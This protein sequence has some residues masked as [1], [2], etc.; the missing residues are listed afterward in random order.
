MQDGTIIQ[1][2]QGLTEPAIKER[3]QL[4]NLG[5]GVLSAQNYMVVAIKERKQLIHLGQAIINLA[6][7]EA[8]EKADFPVRFFGTS[9]YQLIVY[10]SREG[11]GRFED[12]RIC[13]DTKA[14]RDAAYWE[15]IAKN[16]LDSRE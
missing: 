1:T 13:Y 11:L 15:A 7:I 9:E 10:Y 5:R 6:E 8:A 3:K 12:F 2:D 16:Q 14:E 4:I